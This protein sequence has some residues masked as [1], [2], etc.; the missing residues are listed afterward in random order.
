MTA[1][2]IEARHR[3]ALAALIQ[4]A[5]G[6]IR[7]AEA[8]DERFDRRFA[9]VIGALWAATASTTPSSTLL[10]RS[11]RSRHVPAYAT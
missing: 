5:E 8:L 7:F 9:A 10:N 1:Y 2:E 3:A 4:R 11:E 6:G